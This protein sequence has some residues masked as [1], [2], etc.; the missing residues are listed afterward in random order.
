MEATFKSPRPFK[1]MFDHRLDI[2]EISADH[3]ESEPYKTIRSNYLWMVK[4]LRLQRDEN[5][6]LQAHIKELEVELA[7]SKENECYCYQQH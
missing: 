1:N 6:K 7:K 4:I 2:I 5:K 3:T